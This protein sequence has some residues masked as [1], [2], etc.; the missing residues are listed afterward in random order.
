MVEVGSRELKARLGYYLRLVE[1]GETIAIKIHNRIV[2][3]LSQ[4][5]PTEEKKTADKK[6]AE[7]KLKEM[8]R[9]IDQMKKEGFIV[10]GGR[11]RYIPNKPVKMTPGPS[12]TEILRQM[13]DEE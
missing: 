9:K 5:R 1:A 7:K 12:S 6:R 13:R 3:F 4:W 8:D 11:F 2:G 10:S